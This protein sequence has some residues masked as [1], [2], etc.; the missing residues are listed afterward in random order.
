MLEKILF[1]LV[2][3]GFLFVISIID[4]KKQIIP[5]VLLLIAIAFR[6]I[7]SILV[8]K[9]QGVQL[10]GLI[11]DGLAISLPVFLLVLVAEKLSQRE[12]FGG[13]DIKLLFVT[14]MYL[15]WE[16]NLWA[17]FFACIIGSVMGIVQ[18][19]KGTIQESKR[20]FPFGPSIA[21]GAVCSMLMI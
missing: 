2:F 13:G 17:F 7:Y 10:L 21:I 18:L 20:Y 9:M 15:G 6:I 11:I 14:G 16:G 12:T 4:I 8:Q 1:V 19:K 3:I 5:D